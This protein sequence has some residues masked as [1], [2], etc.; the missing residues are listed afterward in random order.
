MTEKPCPEC[1]AELRR[2]ALPLRAGKAGA[3]L[4]PEAELFCPCGYDP[5]MPLWAREIE[6]ELERRES[7][8]T[9]HAVSDPP[10]SG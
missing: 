2:I 9:L 7:G 5:L 10:E 4:P 8:R 6:V 1:G 3:L